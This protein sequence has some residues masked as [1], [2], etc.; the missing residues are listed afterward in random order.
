MNTVRTDAPTT[1]VRNVEHWQ[2]RRGGV[3]D[4]TKP[5]DRFA[6]IPGVGNYRGGAI[7]SLEQMRLL[8]VRYGIKTIVNMATDSMKGQ[9]GEGCSYS[10]K[11]YCEP[12]WASQLGITYLH[13]PLS[14]SWRMTNEKWSLIRDALVQG[15]TYIHCAAGAD[16]TGGAAARWIREVLGWSQNKVMA[17]TRKFGG[18]WD[19]DPDW[20]NTTDHKIGEWV[21]KARYDPTL[22]AR[23]Q[24]AS[25]P[26]TTAS[27]LH[28]EP[29]PW[30][31]MG[32]MLM[33]AV[34]LLKPG[35]NEW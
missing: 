1:F 4:S 12:L 34:F 26:A 24:D 5:P 35:K 13:I 25:S 18:Y 29:K 10:S 8:R 20:R 19:D 32:G 15:H 23:M 11:N 2:W 21:N 31:L 14:R 17:Y 27:T 30:L 16:R 3:P 9:Q 6:S 33:L 28:Q 7:Y 22:L